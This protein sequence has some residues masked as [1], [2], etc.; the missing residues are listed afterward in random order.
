MLKGHWDEVLAVLVT[1]ALA[2][3]PGMGI[4]FFIGWLFE[5]DRV[6]TGI[7]GLFTSIYV[8]GLII[9][10]ENRAPYIWLWRQCKKLFQKRHDHLVIS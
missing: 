7:F 10:E 6:L 3:M 8:M 1:T 9:D 2:F 5:W 4:A